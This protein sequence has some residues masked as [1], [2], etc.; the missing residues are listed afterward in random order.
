MRTRQQLLCSF[1]TLFARCSQVKLGQTF[2]RTDVCPKTLNPVWDSPWFK[3]SVSWKLYDLC[4]SIHVQCTW[5][6]H[7]NVC[8]CTVYLYVHPVLLK[9]LC[10]SP[11]LVWMSRYVYNSFIQSALQNIYI[12]YTYV[13]VRVFERFTVCTCT[14]RWMMKTCKMNHCK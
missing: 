9:L 1:E 13:C 14:Y 10:R 3:F 6:V 4:D 5:Y 8:T 12:L 7:V 11:S 2:H